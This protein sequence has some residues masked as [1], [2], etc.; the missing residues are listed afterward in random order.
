MIRK[1]REVVNY[2]NSS[3]IEDYVGVAVYVTLRSKRTWNIVRGVH[4]YLRHHATT[5]GISPV[6]L[7]GL[8]RQG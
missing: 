4:G 5:T 1:W 6:D 2:V 3:G 7:G 8:L